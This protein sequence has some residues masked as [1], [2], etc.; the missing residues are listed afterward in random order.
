M[1]TETKMNLPSKLLSLRKQKGLTQLEL[2][3][4]LNVSRQA[5]SRWEVGAAIPGTESLKLLCD[6]YGVSMDYLLSDDAENLSRTAENQEPK[7]QVGKL[8]IEKSKRV[9]TFVCA[10]ILGIAIGI[11]V[12]GIAVQRQRQGQ[13]QNVPIGEMS[14]IAEDD[15]PAESFHIGW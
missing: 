9:F 8:K 7:E 11:L 10:L 14:T 3:E 2:A 15:Y 1:E 6:L 4:K 12:C 13:E 5:I